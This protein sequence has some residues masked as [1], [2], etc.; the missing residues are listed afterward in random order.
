M[1][2]CSTCKVNVLAKENFVKFECPNCGETLIV[3]CST[4]KALSNKYTCSKC[5]FT[6]P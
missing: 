6:G 4:C 5:G 3:R 1:F 2:K